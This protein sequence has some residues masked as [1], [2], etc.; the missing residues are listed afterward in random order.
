MA[1]GDILSVTVRNDGFSVDVVID[2]MTPGGTYAFGTLPSAA[3]FTLTVTSEGFDA[4]GVLGTVVRTVQGT[5]I[6]RLA[7]PNEANLDEI[8]DTPIAAQMT[9]RISLSEFVYFDDN[10]GAGKSGTAP[11]VTIAANWYNNPIDPESN[12]QP[13]TDLAVT[14]NSVVIYPKALGQWDYYAGTHGFTRVLADFTLACNAY[15]RFGVAAVIFDADGVTSLNNET[16]TITS[17]TATQR[18]ASGLFAEAYHATIPIAAFTQAEQITCR[19]RVFP[20][21]GDAASVLDTNDLSLAAEI[22]AQEYLGWTEI[23][24]TCDKDDAITTSLIAVVDTAGV[25]ATGIVGTLAAAEAAPFLTIGGAIDA[26]TGGGTPATALRVFVKA[27]TH[28]L[29]GVAPSPRV[30]TAF[31]ITA[32]PHSSTNQAGAILQISSG[33]K[34]YNT[35][36]LMYMGNSIHRDAA[37]GF[38]DG[39]NLNKISYV[40]CLWNVSGAASTSAGPGHLSQGTWYI[41]NEGDLS[42][43]N[44]GIASFSTSRTASVYDGNVIAESTTA[45]NVDSNARFVCNLVTGPVTISQ[46]QSAALNPAPEIDNALCIFNKVVANERNARILLLGNAVAIATGAVVIGNLFEWKT[47]T[48]PLTE[49]AGVTG[50]VASEHIILAHNTFVGERENFGYNDVGTSAVNHFNW[51]QKFNHM[52]DWN[53]KDDTFGTGNANRIGS[54]PVGFGV[55]FVGNNYELSG[56][57]G[58]FP[59]IDNTQDDPPP[60]VF[61]DDQSLSGGGA[62]NGDYHPV[63]ALL[64]RIPTGERVAII[65]FD[66]TTI[67]DDGTGAAGALQV[68]VVSATTTDYGDLSGPGVKHRG[69]ALRLFG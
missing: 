58:E 1:N 48:N 31:N 23:D 27:G 6:M 39:S 50:S 12:S 10:T 38:V 26:S 33:I 56:F 54:W 3:N 68:V 64:S 40:G 19:Y 2:N 49:I 16:L 7:F 14:N 13:V 51:L 42:D 15:H 37:A 62:G 22:L 5:S 24:V 43:F 35:E 69:R 8:D 60:A 45:A 17:K 44:H 36:R 30:T 66:G 18:T 57:P 9:A 21:V 20:V 65:D 28:K 46:Q 63:G 52:R 11:T 61:V 67:P 53:N 34:A 55:G 25:D 29:I 41:N 4:T 59:G 47:G 32:E